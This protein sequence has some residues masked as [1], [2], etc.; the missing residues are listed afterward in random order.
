MLTLSLP[1]VPRATRRPPSTGPTTSSSGTNTSSR[2]ISLRSDFVDESQQPVV[3]GP[4]GQPLVDAQLVGDRAAAEPAWIRMEDRLVRQPRRHPRQPEASTSASSLGSVGC[5]RVTSACAR[6]FS[7]T[8][9]AQPDRFL[10][11]ATASNPCST[12]RQ[13][14]ITID[15]LRLPESRPIHAFCRRFTTP[16]RAARMLRRFVD[17]PPASGGP[18][19]IF[20]RL[21]GRD[22]SCTVASRSTKERPPPRAPTSRPTG[23]ASMTTTWPKAAAWPA[24]S[25]PRPARV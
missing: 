7:P 23:P 5:H 6:A 1:T 19:V 11:A 10:L 13:S 20:G 22:W 9:A 14:L 2:K 16:Y 3:P 25:P 21:V 8:T 17:G 15:P 18:R 4:G 12:A 24:G